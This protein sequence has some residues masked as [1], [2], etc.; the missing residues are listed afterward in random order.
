VTGRAA[1]GAV[2]AWLLCAAVAWPSTERA[3]RVVV[4]GAGRRVEVPARI[5]RVFVAGGPASILLYTLAPDRM[6]GW[7]RAPSPDERAFL[8]SPWADRPALGRL[9]G[10]GNT[11]NVEVALAARPDLI[12][13]Y[14]SIAPTFV[15]L[16]DRV[17]QQT[18]IPYLLL[19]GSLAGIPRAYTALGDVLGVPDRARDLARAAERTLADVNARLVAVPAAQRPSVYYAR[20]PRG[21]ETAR[22]GSINAESLERMGARNPV[23]ERAGA[24]G[25]A[26][27]SFE[28]VLAANPDVVIT[29]DRAFATAARTDGRWRTLPAVQRGRV[30]LAPQLPFPWIDFPPSVNRLIGLRWLGRVLYPAQFPE[31]LRAETRAFYALFYHRAPTESQLDDMLGRP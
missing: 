15:S 2:V 21:L 9:T 20:G 30:F 16:A 28:D 5:E 17:Q 27:V 22:P 13:D 31:D 19:E 4:D 18:G 6:L 29:I 1:T 14:G 11:A 26:A 7:T 25:L 3:R 10:R 8:V 12:L 23:A 24:G